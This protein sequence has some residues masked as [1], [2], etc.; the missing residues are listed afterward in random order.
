M[1]V[2]GLTLLT[3]VLVGN[4]GSPSFGHLKVMQAMRHSQDEGSTLFWSEECD[5]DFGRKTKKKRTET[6]RVLGVNC[7][8]ARGIL[9][10]SKDLRK[11]FIDILMAF[12][13]NPQKKT[14]SAGHTQWCYGPDP[15]SNRPY[16]SSHSSEGH[17]AQH[18]ES[19]RATARLGATPSWWRRPEQRNNMH[20]PHWL[21]VRLIRG[22]AVRGGRPLR[23]L[24]FLGLRDPVAW[25]QLRNDGGE[26]H[27]CGFGVHV[28]K[29]ATLECLQRHFNS[30]LLLPRCGICAFAHTGLAQAQLAAFSRQVKGVARRARRL[31]KRD[32]GARQGTSGRLP[33]GETTRARRSPG[34]AWPS[35][36]EAVWELPGDAGATG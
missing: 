14:L 4:A 32:V 22:L 29:R 31:Q 20:F 16:E 8:S 17:L 11:R 9:Q 1:Q 28:P 26:T 24:S 30:Q 18:W 13:A 5:N 34:S 15:Q 2:V 7:I 23:N 6:V 3:A 36:A 10:L 12:E 33:A 25:L 21:L 27:A 35:W 19:E